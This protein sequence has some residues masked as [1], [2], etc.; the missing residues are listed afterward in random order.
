ML[1]TYPE[2]KNS[3]GKGTSL[4]IIVH[5]YNCTR[6]EAIGLS[7]S[8][9]LF[10]RSPRIAVDVIFGIEL[11]ASLNYP[12]YVKEWQSAMKEANASKGKATP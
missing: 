3:H 11:N 4:P 10:G 7:P 5:F 2:T 9:L 1:R 6:H 12:T 8:F